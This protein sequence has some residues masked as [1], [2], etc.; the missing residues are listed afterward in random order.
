MFFYKR[1]LKFYFIGFW[2]NDVGRIAIAKIRMDGKHVAF[3]SVY[4]PNTYDVDFYD[5]LTKSMFDLVGFHL[6]QGANFNA[7]WDSCMDRK[8]GG[9]SRDQ[10]VS[11]EALRQWAPDTGTV[12]IWHIGLSR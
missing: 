6:V 5:M 10:R 3:I 2:A 9:K 7:V 1:K 8:D 12:D 11:S 4:A